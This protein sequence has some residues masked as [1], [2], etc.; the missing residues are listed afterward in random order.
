MLISGTQLQL[1]A[2]SVIY[3]LVIFYI[4]ILRLTQIYQQQD[5]YAYY[6]IMK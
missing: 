1:I 4:C 3:P 2:D 6:Y 5:I